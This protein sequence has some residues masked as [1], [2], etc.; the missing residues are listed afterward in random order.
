MKS[1]DFI[2]L[3]DP[4]PFLFFL[5]GTFRTSQPVSEEQ[6]IFAAKQD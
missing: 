1:D 4:S 6:P 2:H 3:L 5:I